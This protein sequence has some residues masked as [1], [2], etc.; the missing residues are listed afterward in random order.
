MI[1]EDFGGCSIADGVADL[2]ACSPGNPSEDL[3]FAIYGQLGR[4]PSDA[5]P[6]GGAGA[7]KSREIKG[8]EC[9]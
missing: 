5:G 6:R 7:R 8:E 1:G 9:S 4:Y 3:S 2:T